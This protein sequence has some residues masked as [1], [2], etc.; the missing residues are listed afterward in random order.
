MRKSCL[1]NIF[2]SVALSASA[3]AGGSV[4][5]PSVVQAQGMEMMAAVSAAAMGSANSGVINKALADPTDRNINELVTAGI[6]TKQREPYVRAAIAETGIPA[7]TR[8]EDITEQQ[9]QQVSELIY[10]KQRVAII[11]SPDAATAV[12]KGMPEKLAPYFSQC[13]DGLNF[14]VG[15]ETAKAAEACMEDKHWEADMKPKLELALGGLVLASGA[16][17]ASAFFSSRRKR[18]SA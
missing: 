15:P 9:R 10:A 13:R 14:P 8:A 12:A 2:L 16:V 1:R 5:S 11:S 7:G 17:A 4:V 6:V 3:V 18:P